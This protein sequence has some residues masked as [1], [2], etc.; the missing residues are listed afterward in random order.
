MHNADEML[1][2]VNTLAQVKTENKWNSGGSLI[3]WILMGTIVIFLFIMIFSGKSH[4]K[5]E[6]TA[7]PEVSQKADHQ[8]D[9]QQ[10]LERLKSENV[11]MKTRLSVLQQNVAAP[12]AVSNEYMARQNAPTNMYRDTASQS[13][14]TAGVSEATSATFAGQS[15]FEQFAN[16]N[17]ASSTVLAT[18]VAHPEYAILSGEF[19]HAV[20]ETAINSD[21]PGMVRAIVSKPVYA[22]T[23]NLPLIPAGSRLIGQYSSTVL[24]GQ[25]RV[26]VIWNRVILPNGISAQ[27]NSPGVDALGV[28]GQGADD[29]NTH[30]FARFGQA[31]LLSMI[32]AGASNYGVGPEDPYNSSASYRMA[33]AQSFQQSAQQ[34]LQ[35]SLQI[36][37]T[38]TIHQ[39]AEINVFVARDIDFYAVLSSRK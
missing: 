17:T 35:S 12:P 28:A 1:E 21:L 5:N 14:S 19:L 33:I 6:S 15:P 4:E 38:I 8:A 18:R 24:Q 34:S 2:P 26:F 23:S 29:V 20:L 39:G 13:V 31:S 9:L 7:Q 10:N 3:L 25:N 36:K 11:Q 16:Q 27:I 30:F 37:P 32:G 22:Y